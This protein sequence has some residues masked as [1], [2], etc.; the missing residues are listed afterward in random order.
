MKCD[1][2]MWSQR[3]R[4]TG[5]ERVSCVCGSGFS[6][7]FGFVGWN[8]AKYVVALGAL[9]GIVTGVLVSGPPCLLW[10]DILAGILA[11]HFHETF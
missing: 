2:K 3:F 10:H 4:G 5:L 6:A 9:L 11:R 8:W 1:A 7:A